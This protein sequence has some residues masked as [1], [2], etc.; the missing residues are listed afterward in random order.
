MK[1]IYHDIN[2]NIAAI[3]NDKCKLIK[4]KIDE[5]YFLSD[6]EV[7]KTRLLEFISVI[8]D[9]IKHKTSQTLLF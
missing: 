5:E 4:E 9:F 3:Y 7:A 8:D 2:I 6:N 1:K